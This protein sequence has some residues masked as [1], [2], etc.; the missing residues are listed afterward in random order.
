MTAEFTP[1]TRAVVRSCTLDGCHNELRARG[2][3]ATHWARWRKYGTPE[4][5]QRVIYDVCTI[6]DCTR[7]TRSKSSPYCEAHYYRRRRTG[8]TA[9]P[10]RVYGTVCVIDGCQAEAT[11]SGQGA[12]GATAGYCRLHYLRLK[13]RGNPYFEY[14]RENTHHWTGA[15]A[16]NRA[17]HQ[18]LK[19]QRGKAR[20][21]MCTDCA[22]PA[23]H[24]SY[25]HTDP[26]ELNDPEK[27]SY[28]LDPDRYLPRC[29]SCHKLFDLAHLKSTRQAS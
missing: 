8:T 4:L 1:E 9:D 11:F 21:Y 2:Y 25:D 14:R 29:A 27:G 22:C 17:V 16:T 18:R 20:S 13:R 10:K 15:D 24:W 12:R 6:E 7:K 28:S 5:P 19:A 26:D 3:C 23:L